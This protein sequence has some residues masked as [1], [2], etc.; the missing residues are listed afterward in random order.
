MILLID[1]NVPESVTRLLKDR[2]HDVRLVRELLPAG[3]PDPVIAVVGNDLGAIVV[4]WNHKD[5][6]KLVARVPRATQA[7]LRK[8]GRINFRCHEARGRQRLEEMI[9]WVEFE[10]AQ[11]QKKK[12]KRLMVEI[13]ETY[14]RV[15]R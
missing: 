6:K 3:T 12:D 5:F 10:Y 1:E 8:L 11:V 15:I 7:S 2:G 4:T 13:G 9:E 14:F